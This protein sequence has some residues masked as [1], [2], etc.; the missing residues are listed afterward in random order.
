MGTNALHRNVAV[1]LTPLAVYD[2]RALGNT[3]QLSG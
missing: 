3:S 1:C 2:I